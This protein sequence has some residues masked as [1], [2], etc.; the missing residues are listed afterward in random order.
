MIVFASLSLLFRY[1]VL[2]DLLGPFD[3]LICI[4]NVFNKIRFPSECEEGLSLHLA[5]KVNVVS[6]ST[7]LCGVLLLF[8]FLS[9]CFVRCLAWLLHCRIKLS[10]VRAGTPEG[11]VLAFRLHDAR[12]LLWVSGINSVVS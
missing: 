12:F 6:I 4:Q 9:V 10:L 3:L 5:R 11:T 8:P 1:R 2:R 7:R